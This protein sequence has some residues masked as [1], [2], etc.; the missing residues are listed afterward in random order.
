MRRIVAALAVALAAGPAWGQATCAPVLEMLADLYEQYGEA[1]AWLGLRGDGRLVEL[2][3]DHEHGTWTLLT[4]SPD[5]RACM[6]AEG[7]GWW[8]PSVSQLP[9]AD[10]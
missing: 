4:I 3:I 7:D 6:W 10:G 1:P 5:G 8:R 2:V 9:G